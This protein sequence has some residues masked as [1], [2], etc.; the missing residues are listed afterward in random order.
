[1]RSTDRWDQT[2]VTRQDGVRLSAPV[3]GPLEPIPQDLAHYVVEK[4]LGL[5]DGL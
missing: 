3:F 4:E 2:I 1:M 5:R